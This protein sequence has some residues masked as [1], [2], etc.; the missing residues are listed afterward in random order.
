[1]NTFRLTAAALAALGLAASANAADVKIYG[2]IDTGLIYQNYFGDSTK[3][4]AFKMESGTNTASRAGIEGLE[5]ISDDLSVGFRLESRFASDSGELKGDRLFE[6]NASVKLASKQFGEVAAGRISG[7]GSGSGPYDLQYCMDV[8]GGGTNGTGMSPVKTSRMDNMITYRSPKISGL[9]ATLQHSLKTDSV[10]ETSLGDESESSANRFYGAG[11]HYTAG[12]LDAELLYEQ[13]DWGKANA[14]T[15]DD[16]KTVVTLGGSYRIDDLKLFLQAQ[17]FNGV[18]AF[19][20]F[21]ASG[22]NA[23][24][25]LK[26]WGLYAGS[27]VWFGPHSLKT[28]AYWHDYKTNV[29]ATGASVDGSSAGVGTKFLYRPSKTVELYVGCGYSQWDRLDAGLVKT[30][31]SVNAYGGMTKYF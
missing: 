14:N 24:T 16:D 18:E 15:P 4:D 11:L 22:A 8:F 31:K 6:G 25:G 29:K 10:S 27:E 26:G 19:D 12:P 17:Y 2:R 28:M 3:A 21:A 23:M 1:M 13:T 9:Q 5:E 7:I 20:G 30:D